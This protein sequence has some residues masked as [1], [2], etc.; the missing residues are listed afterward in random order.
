[1][2]FL[3]NYGFI[4]HI[5][6]L[7]PR[8]PHKYVANMRFVRTRSGKVKITKVSI[9]LEFYKEWKRSGTDSLEFRLT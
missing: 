8:L 6:S 2:T 3:L 5:V 9:Q 1:M 4:Q 7:F